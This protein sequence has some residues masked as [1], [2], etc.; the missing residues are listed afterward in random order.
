MRRTISIGVTIGLCAA[1]VWSTPAFAVN[2]AVNS[3]N[4]PGT[5]VCDAAECTLREAIV[6][7]NTNPGPDSI[8]F[9]IP[10]TVLHTITPSTA[11]PDI[12][13]GLTIDGYTQDGA[14]PNTLAVGNNA[15]LNIELNGHNAGSF[16]A[17]L[18]FREGSSNSTVRGLVIRDFQANGIQVVSFGLPIDPVTIQGNYI[19]TDATGTMAAGNARAI[20]VVGANNV[21]IGGV[22]PDERNI[23][24]GSVG[25][26]IEFIGND[27]SI[28]GNYIGTAK[29]GVTPLPNAGGGIFLQGD[30]NGVGGSDD[31]TDDEMPGNVIAFNAVPSTAQFRAAIFVA[32]GGSGNAILTNSIFSN[33]GRGIALGTARVPNDAGDADTGPNLLQNFPVLKKAI[34]GGGVTT[35][36]GKLL[37]VPSS[38]FT[39]Q[40][41]SNRRANKRQGELFIGEAEVVTAAGGGV[42]F[43]F[44]PELRLSL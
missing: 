23:L 15:V 4:D 41:F 44:T 29:D 27:G 33:G 12:T 9:A 7:A 3:T 30:D 34:T 32:D 14:S 19:G 40:F 28:R 39:L 10:G 26:G 11:L 35:I 25:E 37:S 6:A 8:S 20:R 18:S 5:G 43:T 42:R 13:D 38:S 2:F 36:K 1:L 21:M 17:G 16:G 31:L 24:S 22:L